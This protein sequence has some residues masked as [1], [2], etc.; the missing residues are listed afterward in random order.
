M[1]EKKQTKVAVKEADK[2]E[3]ASELTKIRQ[4]LETLVEL[5]KEE[6]INDKD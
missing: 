1:A 2:A 4:I 5:I 6:I 3:I